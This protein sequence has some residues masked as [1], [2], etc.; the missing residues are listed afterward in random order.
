MSAKAVGR[1][2]K[3]APTNSTNYP[4]VGSKEQF[5]AAQRGKEA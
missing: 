5:V 3:R 4:L 2:S 1:F